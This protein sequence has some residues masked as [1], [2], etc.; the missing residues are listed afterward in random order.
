M[1][2]RVKA[3]GERGEE[4]PR[5]TVQGK[6]LI[7]GVL[8]ALVL[9]A[10]LL[11]WIGMTGGS[12]HVP[13]SKPGVGFRADEAGA[14]DP[15]ASAGASAAP[16]GWD[17]GAIASTI[18]DR[19]VRE[20]LR[21]RI[22]AGWAAEGEPEVAA[23]AK[24]GRFLPAPPGPDGGRMDPKYIQEVV[25][26]EFFPMANKCYEELLTRKKKAKGR[27]EMSFTIV[28]DEKHGGI[29]EDVE[30][31]HG[32]GGLADEK[33]MT[34]MRESMSTLAFRPPAHGGYVTVVYPI[35][36]SDDDEDQHDK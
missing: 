27:V 36:F 10:G 9:V 15:A 24:Q 23:A 31:D 8:G 2:R 7:L 28:A 21:N 20:E 34:C 14:P 17:G 11:F 12:T 4:R 32:D 25:R 13:L 35:E 26:G 29:L 18:H 19:K 3:P 6:A 33:M 5:G 1:M 30:A 22:L 16:A